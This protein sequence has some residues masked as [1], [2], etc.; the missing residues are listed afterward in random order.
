MRQCV[1]DYKGWVGAGLVS[2]P[3]GVWGGVL[4]LRFTWKWPC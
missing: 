2:A 3:G 4:E 1:T